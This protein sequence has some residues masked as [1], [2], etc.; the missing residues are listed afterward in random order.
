[1]VTSLAGIDAAIRPRAGIERGLVRARG[2]ILVADVGQPRA[3]ILA[4]I[5]GTRLRIGSSRCGDLR[6]ALDL[7]SD[8]A[9]ALGERLG[10]RMTTLR[11]PATRLAEAFA[12]A[13]DPRQ[14]KVVV[15]HE[16]PS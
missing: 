1:V 2:T 15:E 13:A 12:A 8:P 11:V 6:A 4:A 16:D 7:L 5:L 9:L 3:G 14:V 10:E